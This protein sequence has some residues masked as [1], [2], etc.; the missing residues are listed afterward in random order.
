MRLTFCG[1][2]GAVTGA[3]Y[4]LETGKNKILIDCGLLQGSA[5]NNRRNFDDFVY[6]PKEIDAVILTHAHLDHCGR[7]PWLYHHGFRGRIIGTAPTKDLTKLILLD[8]ERIW[9]KQEP[10]LLK[11]FNLADV[12]GVLG[13]FEGFDYHQKVELGQDLSCEFKD[14][15]H[16]LGSTIVKVDALGQTIIFSGDL[17]N[18]PTP[19][20]R[21]PEI[22]ETADYLV[23]ESAY[24]D[25]LHQSRQECQDEF[26]NLIEDTVAKAGILMMPVFTIERAQELLYELNNLVE[27]KRIPAVP[28]FLDSPLAIEA[29]QV[30][31]RYRQYFNPEAKQLARSDND[32]FAFP[33]LRSTETKEESKQINQVSPPKIILAG[34]GM[35]EGG[36]I[37][38]HELHYLS[39]ANNTLLVLGYQAEGTLGR[40]LVDGQA[41]VMI[42][43]S[44]VIV[45][46][47][48][49]VLDGFSAHADQAGLVRWTAAIAKPIKKIFIVQGEKQASQVLGRTISDCLGISTV[50]PVTNQAFEL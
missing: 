34:S 5:E 47:R 33:G 31:Q 2:A 18:P 28:M 22:V 7:L 40:K 19:L 4:L 39:N 29:T 44:P 6:N 35:S 49:V 24:G 1:G 27:Q 20:L 41:K 30:Y 14:A 17:G 42:F 16:I 12:N 38:Y 45:R 11:L 10:H 48:V 15:G 37:C 8:S 13:L 46:A 25:R 9:R 23:I 50:A 21:D 43:G 26:E 36:R 32:I 3:N